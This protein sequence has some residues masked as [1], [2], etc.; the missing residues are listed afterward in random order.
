MLLKILQNVMFLARQNIALRCDK[1]ESDS[2]FNQLLQ[3]RACDDSDIKDWLKKKT[4][5]YTSAKI[6][7]EMLEVMALQVLRKLTSSLQESEFFT[8]MVDECTD[9]ANHEQLAVCLRLVDHDLEIYQEFFGL[10]E[11]PDVA[12]VTIIVFV[13]TDTLIRM[14]L[15]ISRC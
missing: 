2:N 10:Y 1:D 15:N 5:K 9:S 4:D 13:I 8:I 7:N 14:N 6:Q 3:L 12:A 11:I